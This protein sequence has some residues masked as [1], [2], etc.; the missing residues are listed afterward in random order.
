[1][2]EETCLVTRFTLDIIVIVG[3][4]AIEAVLL[5]HAVVIADIFLAINY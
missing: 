2:R 5:L 3:F 4:Y 1:M